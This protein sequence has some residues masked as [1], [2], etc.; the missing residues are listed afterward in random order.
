MSG[1]HYDYQYSRINQMAND[2]EADFLNDGVKPKD[3]YDDEYDLLSDATDAERVL[4]LEE[5]K[6]LII[7][8][9]KCSDR[10]KEIEWLTSGDT[11]ATTYLKR[12][13]EI[14]DGNMQ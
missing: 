6:Q 9:R 13:K 3:K 4:I 10:A 8:L 11:G 1:G 7:D 12:L 14:Y 5:V 2:I